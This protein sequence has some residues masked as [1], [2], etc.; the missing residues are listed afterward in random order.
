MKGV[1]AKYLRLSHEDG[2]LEEHGKLESNSIVNQRNLLNAYISNHDDLSEMQILEFCDDGWS[3]KNFERPAV[4]EMLTQVKQG[5]IQ[6]IIVKDLSRFGRDYL[7]VGNYISRVF[8]FMGVRFIAINDGFDSIRPMEAD[9]LETSF[10]A[11]LYDLYSRDLSR[12]VRGAR[13][14]RAMR[15]DF[16]SAFAPYGYIKDPKNH[17][18]LVI[19]PEAAKVVRDIFR[20]AGEGK[21]TVEI[22]KT[23]NRDHVLTRM[24]YKR[25]TGCSRTVWPCV[26]PDNY[27]T[28]TAVTKILRDERYLGKTVYGKRMCDKV[29]HWHSVKVER[30]EWIVMD[31]THEGIVTPEE[32]DQATANL[33]KYVPHNGNFQHRPLE[34]KI[35]C[36]V[37]GHVMTRSPW[38]ASLIQF[39]RTSFIKVR[40][41]KL[42]TSEGEVSNS[43]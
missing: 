6:C 22:A 29:G 42:Y 19:D 43:A 10:K 35:H 4:L 23:L 18:R 34:R 12:K 36:G 2:D 33:K 15:G 14:F 13:Q 5:N 38:T 7:E 40:T 41:F 37:C 16:L 39:E 32:F 3:G 30:T 9:S 1:I 28:D 20:M 31:D 17:S 26:H 25:E 8:P 11:L 21:S 24:C 27:W